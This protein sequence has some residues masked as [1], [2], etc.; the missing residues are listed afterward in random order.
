M[1][2][3]AAVKA[4]HAARVVPL[5]QPP[6]L[7]S[8]LPPDFSP[9]DDACFLVAATCLR[10]SAATCGGI[11]ALLPVAA[12]DEEA[13]EA[14]CRLAVQA[15]VVPIRRLADIGSGIVQEVCGSGAVGEQ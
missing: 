4:Q 11:F 8:L 13:L 10:S 15:S 5:D 9:F 6:P 14:K 12:A 3:A 2:P 7:P 1:D